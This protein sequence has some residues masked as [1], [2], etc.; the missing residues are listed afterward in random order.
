MKRAVLVALLLT[1]CSKAFDPA[2]SSFFQTAGAELDQRPR[3]TAV[4]TNAA[5]QSGQR[6]FAADLGTRFAREVPATVNFAF[7]SA[8]LDVQAQAVLRQQ[9]DWIRQFP[10][11]R[12]RVYGFTDKVGSAPSNQ[13]LGMRRAQAVLRFLTRQGIS[14]AR[15][16]AVS[17]FGETRPVID[18]AGPERR[19]RR[20]VT[21]VTGF[22]QR[23]PSVLNGEYASVIARDY[24]ASAAPVS[25]LTG[26]RNSV[27]G[28]E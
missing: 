12:F 10:E 2:S 8:A 7:G 5:I 13:R 27:T 17:S 14:R 16:Q 1:G 15:L 26:L 21:E 24:V 28:G 4:D 3:S 22:V 18:S 19:N 9:A 11:L 20:A 25:R 23:H 6:G